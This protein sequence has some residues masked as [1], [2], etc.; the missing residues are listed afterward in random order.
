VVPFAKPDRPGSVDAATVGDQAGAIRVTWQAPAENGRP[1]TAY[2][3]SGGG[4]SAEVSNATS[5]TLTGFGSG[6]TV[7]V[8]VRA[9]N[10]A[11][12]SDPGTATAKTVDKPVVTITGS[13]ATF[14]TATVTFS[15]DAGG[16]TASCSVASNN[17]GGSASGS[18][19]S[20]QV[21]SLK[22]STAYTFTV[23]AK[24]AAGTVTQT[25][26]QTTDDLYG[27]TRCINGQNGDTATY[28]SSDRPNARN[29]DEIF[30]VPR[31]DNAKQVGW[32]P[33]GT[34]LK[35]FCKVTGDDVDS[36]IYNSHK[37]STLWIQISYGGKK[38]YIP[39]A[40]LNLD[41]GDDTGVLPNC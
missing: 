16:G 23:T 18:C 33:T 35:A 8:E 37:H 38:P 13:S 12:Q 24:N 34:R 20:L 15:V 22:P 30:S 26:A 39:W 25:R 14:N 36:Y 10:E 9:V 2:L 11:G 5:A 19:S 17:G 7:A 31:Q 21:K 41:G 4:K 29:G 28:C 6:Q 32:E 40:W 1:I 3:V 27:T